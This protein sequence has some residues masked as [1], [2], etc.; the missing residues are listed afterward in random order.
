MYVCMYDTYVYILYVCTNV[1]MYVCMY[2][3]IC[4]CMCVYIY[5]S[6]VKSTSYGIRETD[7]YMSKHVCIF[8]C[9]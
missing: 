4:V 7:S 9:V 6:S 3:Y 5:A 8:V 2:V 1:R